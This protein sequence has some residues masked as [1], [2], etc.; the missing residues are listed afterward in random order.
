VH[1]RTFTLSRS[2]RSLT[3]VDMLEGRGTHRLRWHFHFSPGV[4]ASVPRAGDVDIQ[5]ASRPLRLTVPPELQ[6]TIGDSWY[7]PSYGVREPCVAVDAEALVTL[8]GRHEFAFGLT[9]R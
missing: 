4:T 5:L 7:S 9:P 3:I 1:E 2:D 6:L 8:D